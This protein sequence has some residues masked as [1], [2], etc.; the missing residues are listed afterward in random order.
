M[1]HGEATESRQQT[2]TRISH[3]ASESEKDRFR[4]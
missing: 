3:L 1:A 2:M 4:C